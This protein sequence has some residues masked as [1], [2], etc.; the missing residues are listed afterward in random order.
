MT[1]TCAF[2]LP[3]RLPPSLSSSLPV[4]LSPT[5]SSVP[6]LSAPLTGTQVRNR[7]YQRQIERKVGEETRKADIEISAGRVQMTDPFKRLPI[8]PVIYWGI[9]EDPNGHQAGLAFLE[10]NQKKEGVITT[11]SGLQ[12]KVLF[13]GDGREH[14]GIESKCECHY[15]GRL[16]DGTEFD[17]SYSRGE[18]ETFEPT[19]VIKGWTEALQL[20]VVGDK[21]ELYCP[22]ELA[23]GEKGKPSAKIPAK[24]MLTFVMELVNIKGEKIPSSRAPKSTPLS[25]ALPDSAP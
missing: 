14:P 17:S 5:V 13:E 19:K 1:S 24:A 9:K 18:T 10:E 8:R 11:K 25:T 12:Y 20:M 23:Y 3:P 21:W 2:P 16:L 4:P 6:F 22:F 7:E 15:A